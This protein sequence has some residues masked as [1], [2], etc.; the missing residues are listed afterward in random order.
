MAEYVIENG[1]IYTEDETI[2]KG[3]LIIKAGKI[4]GVGKGKYEGELTT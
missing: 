1:R 2:E 4:A 3:Y